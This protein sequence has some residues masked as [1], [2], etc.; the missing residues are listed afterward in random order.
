MREQGNF[1]IYCVA[2]YKNAKRLTGKLVSE[3]FTRYHIGEYV[4]ECFGALHTTGANYIVQ[5]I[6]LFIKSR[7]PTV[8]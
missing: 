1:L 8:E 7:Q 5:D 3:L 2:T 4:Y 6:D